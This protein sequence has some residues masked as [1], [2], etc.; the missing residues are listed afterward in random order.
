MKVFLGQLQHISDSEKKF[1]GPLEYSTPLKWPV[2]IDV[3]TK[4]AILAR[5]RYILKK[6]DDYFEQNNVF[7]GIKWY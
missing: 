6:S 3:F 4:L 2:K 7:T 1:S 5:N